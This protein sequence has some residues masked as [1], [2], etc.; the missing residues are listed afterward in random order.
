MTTDPSVP[1]ATVQSPR[2]VTR[3]VSVSSPGAVVGAV[4]TLVLGLALGVANQ[5]ADGT[6]MALR[7][8]ALLA[9]LLMVGQGVVDLR[10]NLPRRQVEMVPETADPSTRGRELAVVRPMPPQPP[11]TVLATRPSPST[12]SV[13]LAVIFLAAWLGLADL[14]VD[15]PTSLTVLSLISSFA[16]FALGWG[17]LPARR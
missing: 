10:K 1:R 14:R 2:Q 15:A 7:V 4:L 16:L 5:G 13:P 9:A 11:V 3:V 8:P 6:A 17:L 12:L